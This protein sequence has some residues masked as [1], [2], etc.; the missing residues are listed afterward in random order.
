MKIRELL[1][2]IEKRKSDYP[3]ILDWDIYIQVIDTI[4]F[5]N[6]KES[7]WKFL[8]DSEDWKYIKCHGF[9]TYYE[10]EKVLTINA[11]Y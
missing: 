9:N 8:T 2:T 4:D 10:K 7:G 11:D 3:D 6:K 5:N 1:E